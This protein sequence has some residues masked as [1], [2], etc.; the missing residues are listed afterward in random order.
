[1]NKRES[2]RLRFEEDAFSHG[3]DQ[4]RFEEMET[5]GPKRSPIRRKDKER[6]SGIQPKYRRNQKKKLSRLKYDYGW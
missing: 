4:L 3:T 5:D 1:M 6:K 2:N